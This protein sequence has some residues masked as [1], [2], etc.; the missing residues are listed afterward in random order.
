MG[1]L[2]GW[3]LLLGG[4]RTLASLSAM[5]AEAPPRQ[6]SARA[7]L[8]QVRNGGLGKMES[9]GRK[10]RQK[11]VGASHVL[12]PGSTPRGIP[13]AMNHLCPG[14]CTVCPIG[15]LS[16]LATSTMFDK[17]LYKFPLVRYLLIHN[18]PKLI[19]FLLWGVRAGDR[20]IDEPLMSQRGILHV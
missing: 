17:Y 9:W 4:R 11:V 7:P 13:S 6:P 16:D 15:S 18:R 19:K 5:P 10:S 8:Q 14:G 20:K 1:N 2:Q 12:A 3:A